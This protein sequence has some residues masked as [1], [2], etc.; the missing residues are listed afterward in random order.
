MASDVRPQS[1]S[2][3]FVIGLQVS[4]IYCICH[5]SSNRL[6]HPVE[7]KKK[8]KKDHSFLVSHIKFVN[9]SI[10][11]LISCERPST[12]F[13]KFTPFLFKFRH[14]SVLWAMTMKQ[15]K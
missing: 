13:P 3:A 4:Q 2:T 10:P 8:K 5:I 14:L 7:V 15:C 12:K 1:T 6:A 11:I 9:S